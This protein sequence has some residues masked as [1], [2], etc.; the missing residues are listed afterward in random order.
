ML[1][2]DGTRLLYSNSSHEEPGRLELTAALVEG[3]WRSELGDMA[4]RA[5]LL[6]MLSDVHAL[7]I[8]AHFHNDQD[9]VSLGTSVVEQ[10]AGP[11]EFGV[12]TLLSTI[13]LW[14]YGF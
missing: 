1:I 3:G 11:A 7:M 13:V 10:A 2:L 5:D 6:D 4:T 12:K 8:R 14:Y 9:E